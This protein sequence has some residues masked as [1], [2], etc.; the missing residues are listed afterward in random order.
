M[1]KVK[2]KSPVTVELQGWRICESMEHV[3]GYIYF[4]IDCCDDGI[5][6]YNDG[7]QG[8]LEYRL[9]KSE[10]ELCEELE[11]DYQKT[12]QG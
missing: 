9:S 3:D 1:G 6:W 2:D 8:I 11:N 5:E 10:P 7:D 4:R 12:N